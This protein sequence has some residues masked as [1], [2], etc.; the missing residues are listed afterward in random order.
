MRTKKRIVEN[1]AVWGDS[2]LKGVVLD[3]TNTKYNIA[4]DNCATVFS[5]LSNINVKNNSRFGCTAQK[6]L[7]NL[8]GTLDKG[9][10]PDVILI[11]FGGND[12]DYNWSEVSKSPDIEHKSKTPLCEFK[13]A[14][15]HM[16]DVIEKKGIQPLLMDLPPID[17][18]K[19]FS[20]ITNLKDVSAEKV[21]MWLKEKAAIYRNQE[22]Y[23]NAIRDISKEHDIPMID[24]RSEFLGI[25]N[26]TDYLCYDGIHLNE[27]GQNMLGNIFYQY[28]LEKQI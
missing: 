24:V 1:V 27:K 2:L 3:D 8:K 28:A 13:Q 12:S 11:E 22:R 23:S 26:Y 20:W 7:V 9:F 17:C 10:K 15:I 5:G 21:L 19:Y 14:I 16:I 6:A 18:E 25:R 4:K